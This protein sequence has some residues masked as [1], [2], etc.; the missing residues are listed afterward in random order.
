MIEPIDLI[1]RALEEGNAPDIGIEAMAPDE[2]RD[3]YGDLTEL[4]GQSLQEVGGDRLLEY[5]MGQ[6]ELWADALAKALVD[7][8]A[9][10]DAA[11]LDA[12]QRFMTLMDTRRA[13][14]GGYTID[15]ADKGLVDEG[16][17]DEGLA[18]EG[19][20][21]EGLADEGLADEGLADEGL[22]DEGLADEGLDDD[23][24]DR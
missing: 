12:A 20:A 5:Y 2:L 7:A 14:R 1:L 9:D 15:F 18:D 6:P 17:A 10:H 24:I 19:L 11:L 21:D 23:E 16:L 8:G 13:A 22:A 4:V 3:E